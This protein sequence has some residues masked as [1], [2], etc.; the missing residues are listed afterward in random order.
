[1]DA[2]DAI[3]GRH[4]VR[5]YI[6]AAIPREQL[7]TIVDCGRLAATAVNRQPWEFV[8]VTAQ[9]ALDELTAI[10]PNNAPFFKDCGA[11]VLVLSREEKYY[12][13]DC[14][15]ATQNI[16]IAATAL[17]LGTC[18]VAGDKKDYAP[19]VLSFAGAPGGFRLV[20]MV[21]IGVAAEKGNAPKR[22]LS[23]V[24]HWEQ[25]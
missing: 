6:K 16:L 19:A 14:A 10:C 1:M 2:I 11:V 21:G 23:E 7:E 3:V 20:S 8:V 5:K 4:S 25:F 24:L 18:W 12:L 17:G 22:K 15:A 13:E 9:A